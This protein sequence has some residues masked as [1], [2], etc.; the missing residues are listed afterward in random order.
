[1]KCRIFLERMLENEIHSGCRSL[2][3][4]SKREK[5]TLQREKSGGR[6]A[7]GNS[8]ISEWGILAKNE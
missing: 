6:K 3:R 1:M 5:E 4:G 7:M 2:K 8:G